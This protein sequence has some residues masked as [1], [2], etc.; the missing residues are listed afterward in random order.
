M[1]RYICYDYE[2]TG[3]DTLKDIP[4]EIGAIDNFG[5]KFQCYVKISTELSPKVQEVTG[6]TKSFLES[7][8]Y[9]IE[10]AFNKFKKYIF[11]SGRY[12]NTFLIA[13]NGT[14]FDH[15]ITDRLLKQYYPSGDFRHLYLDTFPLIKLCFPGCKSYK[16]CSL[17]IELCNYK[18]EKEHNALD[19]AISTQK[20]FNK[21]FIQYDK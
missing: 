13:H 9:P 1:D 14:R 8:G 21:L 3:L 12:R 10:I 15:L 7:K 19:D 17:C 4:I 20:L 16:L 2:T 18:P 6:Y 11:D 5:N